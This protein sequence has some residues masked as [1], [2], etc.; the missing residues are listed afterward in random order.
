MT[1]INVDQEIHKS[2]HD[3]VLEAAR[4]KDTIGNIRTSIRHDNIV[5][6]PLIDVR[7]PAFAKDF[8]KSE[9]DIMEN[10]DG[11]AEIQS[12]I[13]QHPKSAFEILYIIYELEQ[14]GH[15]KRM[16]IYRLLEVD[17][18]KQ[19]FGKANKVH[20]SPGLMDDWQSSSMT[21]SNVNT[22]EI[23]TQNRT[24]GQVEFLIKSQVPDG[25]VLLPKNLLAQFGVKTGDRVLVKP[26]L[27]PE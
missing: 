14:K 18:L 27:H 26:L 3:L 19:L 24:Y 13:D 16:D 15:I 17:I 11:Q 6:L 23:R 21:Y 12:I 20:V 7:I 1:P 4:R 25:V 8:N 10:L 22:M 9:L 5:Y 2:I